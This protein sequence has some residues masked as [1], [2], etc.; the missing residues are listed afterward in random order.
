MEKETSENL[1][2]KGKNKWLT[3][4]TIISSA[5][6]GRWS[7]CRYWTKFNLHTSEIQTFHYEALELVDG[8][9]SKS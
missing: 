6:S 1:K 7:L 8:T 9:D 3:H 4:F 5:C 2:R